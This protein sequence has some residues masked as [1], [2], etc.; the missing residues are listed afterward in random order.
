MIGS[1]A[2]SDGSP[3]VTYGMSAVRPARAELRER[4]VDA[5]QSELRDESRTP[6]PL[7]RGERGRGEGSCVNRRPAPPDRTPAGSRT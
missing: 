6:F 2:A 7:S 5:V 4:G 1:V 3:A